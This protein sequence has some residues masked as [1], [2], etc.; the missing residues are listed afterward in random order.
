MTKRLEMDD[1]QGCEYLMI[2]GIRTKRSQVQ[3]RFTPEDLV[4]H[5]RSE[6]TEEVANTMQVTP[7]VPL[8]VLGVSI[9]FVSCVVVCPGG[10]EG[11]VVILDARKFVLGRP[12]E[13]YVEGIQGYGVVEES[14]DKDETDDIPI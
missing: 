3:V 8:R 6:L 14:D 2:M 5:V 13:E 9:P 11:Q 4:E 1:I 7:G 12:T 10:N